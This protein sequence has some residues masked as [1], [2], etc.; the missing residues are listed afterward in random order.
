MMTPGLF[1]GA[2]ATAP[3][4]PSRG[5]ASGNATKQEVD[6]LR[7]EVAEQR[8]TIDELKALVQ[9]LVDAKTAEAKT[10]EAKTAE[11]KT[12]EAKTE[13]PGADGAQVVNATLTQPANG[14]KLVQD[15]QKKPEEKKE[16]PP[17]VAGWNGEHFFIKSADGKF[18]IQPYG[19]VQTDYRAYD[20]DGAPADTFVIRRARLGFQGNYG[21]YYDFTLL[22][23]GVAVQ[24]TNLRDAYVN[25][26]PYPAFQVQVGQ[27]KVPF[28]QEE[29]D[30]D[31]NILFIER[32]LASLLYPNA[33][34]TFRSPGAMV[35]GNIAGGFMQYW[36]GAFNGRGL[37]TNTTQNWP[38][39]VGRLRFY[40]WKHRK[41]SMLQG[42]AF[43]GAMTYGRTRGLSG[44]TSF[45]G[46][47]PDAAY[48]FFPSFIINGPV[49]RY[50]AEALWY[51]G[52]MTVSG[53]Y[54]QLQQQRQ[55]IGSAQANALGFTT[56]PGV[57]AKAGYAQAS[58]L[59]T[60]ETAVENGAPKVKHPLFGPET[61]G[62]KGTGWGAFEL[63]FR[64]DR[65]QAIA[66]GV[67]QL[68]NTF[69]PGFVTTFNNHT[70]AFTFGFNW[71][72]NYWVK[73]LADFSVDRLQQVS[74]NTGALPQ[75]YFV[76]LQRL[77]FRF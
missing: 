13:Q 41:G 4:D 25:I 43:G 44:E 29:V 40:P 38:E 59:L 14:V 69:T 73:Y 70:D 50:E 7:H 35:W 64:Y 3:S 61:P 34:G 1:A 74:I 24:G 71:Y 10:A 42:F 57:G 17:V 49:W 37:A 52:P 47:L 54:V 48:T 28:A 56:L 76:V 75:N 27:Y 11:A 32:S 20:G 62:G 68:N 60:G 66:P 53:N 5:P 36:V 33:V 39:S 9:Q 16:G 31:A 46:Q 8:Q 18:Q 6:Q 63:A 2:Q 58:Y 12:A 65:I 23:D 55:G 72:L 15:S 26:K 77:Q 30:S 19:Y 22:M 51:S 67:N 45:S 21:K